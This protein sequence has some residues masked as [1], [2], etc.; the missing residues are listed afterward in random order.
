MHRCLLGLLLDNDEQASFYLDK[1]LVA[2]NNQIILNTFYLSQKVN[3][4][5]NVKSV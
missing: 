4:I 5:T 2:N 3:K 1:S